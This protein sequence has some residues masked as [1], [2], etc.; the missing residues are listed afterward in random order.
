M[1]VGWEMQVWLSSLPAL[2]GLRWKPHSLRASTSEAAQGRMDHTDRV[3]FGL[4]EI[5][6]LTLLHA[7]NSCPNLRM[8]G[9][10]AIPI[11]WLKKLRV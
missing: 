10:I 3:L 5:T 9:T 4:F 6:N 1:Q 11:S 7:V 8:L 2:D